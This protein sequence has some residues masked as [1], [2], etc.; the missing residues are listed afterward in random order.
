MW[1]VLAPKVRKYPKQSAITT[2][3]GNGFKIKGTDSPCNTRAFLYL[4]FKT[5]PYLPDA[6]LL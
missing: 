3:F 5:D 1:L 2:P 4:Y 6:A